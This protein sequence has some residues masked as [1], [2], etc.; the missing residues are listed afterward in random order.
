MKRRDFNKLLLAGMALPGISFMREGMAYAQTPNGGLTSLLAPEP[1]T[2]MLP[3]NQQQP[4]IVAGAKIFESLLDYD[5]DL[6]PRPQLA[7]SWEISEDGLTY[8]FH[9]VRNAKW[10]DG[11]PF[12]AHDVVFSCSQMLIELHPRAR[13]SFERCESIDAADDHTVVF[14]LKAPFAPFIYAFETVSAPIAPRHIYEGTDYKNN[15]ANDHP[16]GTGLLR[17]PPFP[18]G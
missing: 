8:T 16:I 5:F 15:P 18:P 13:V 11:V 4:T 3:L 1:P 7:E 10:H 9:L 14:K 17:P 6:S 2:L 12:T